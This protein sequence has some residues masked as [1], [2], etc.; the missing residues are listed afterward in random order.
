MDGRTHERTDAPVRERGMDG[1]MDGNQWGVYE[2]NFFLY[3][4]F[5]GCR[6]GR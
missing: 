1:W 5:S 4:A 3:V 6:G 2:A